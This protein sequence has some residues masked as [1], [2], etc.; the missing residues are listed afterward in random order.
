MRSDQRTNEANRR[1][2]AHYRTRC[3]NPRC[4]KSSLLPLA[5]AAAAVLRYAAGRSTYPY[6]PQ[7]RR[8]RRLRSDNRQTADEAASL[9]INI[10]RQTE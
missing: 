6:R 2:C 9:Q 8:E 4:Q 10:M 7:V 3:W 5:A 1:Q